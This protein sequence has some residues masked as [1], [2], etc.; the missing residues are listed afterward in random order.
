M[1]KATKGP[2]PLIAQAA[3]VELA[4]VN[5]RGHVANLEGLVRKNKRPEAELEMAR[6]RLPGL[7]AAHR[8]LQYLSAHE[9][10]LRA[11]LEEQP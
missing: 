10:K 5:L 4:F 2:M 1:P 11:L 6:S 7:E 8:T 9:A 3:A